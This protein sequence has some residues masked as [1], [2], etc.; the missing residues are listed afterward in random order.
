[1]PKLYLHDREK[2]ISAE[3]KAICLVGTCSTFV[4]F[5][6]SLYL[7]FKI[8]VSAGRF[9]DRA[10]ELNDIESGLHPI[11]S[12]ILSLQTKQL[13]TWKDSSAPSE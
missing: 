8:I 12:L 2:K 1:M 5:H 9:P 11:L 10:F 4:F 13:E 6:I 7:C 3:N